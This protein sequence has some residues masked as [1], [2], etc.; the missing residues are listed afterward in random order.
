MGVKS[1]RAGIV[2]AVAAVPWAVAGCGSSGGG[3]NVVAPVIAETATSSGDGQTAQIGTLL[4]GALRVVVTLSGA[5]QQGTTVTWGTSATGA[6][7]NPTSSVTDA[8]GVATTAWTLGSAAGTQHA[9]ATLAGATGSPVTFSATA[10]AAPVPV[11]A[12][13]PTAS[14]NGQT[15][16]VATA[17]ANPLRVL[18]TLSG[19]VQQGVTVG[20]A[21]VG[22]GASVNPTTS[23][24]DA[25]GIAT[26]TWTLG[27]V[28]GAQSATATLAGATGSPVTFAATATPGAATQLLLSS[29]N[30]QSALVNRAFA[31]A[32][33]V[34]VGDQFANGVPGDSVSWLVTSGPA[35]ISPAK[36][37]SNAAG[38]AQASLT[39]G[40]TA[41]SVTVTAT[42][43]TL[44]GS[45]V[46]FNATVT[47]A[48]TTASVDI[49]NFF[50]KSGRNNSSNPAVDTIA[51]GGT[52]TWNFTGGTHGVQSTGT[53]SFT[54]QSTA[55]STGTFTFTFTS[56]GSYSYD[57]LV[58]GTLMTGI[59]VVQ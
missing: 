15:A 24:T 17:L 53:P 31:N 39:A 14:G 35:T 48:P 34:L 52:V 51:A 37:A 55:Q 43:G 44:T 58:H 6:S 49:G 59:I 11:I 29:G 12:M 30:N 2:V 42:S 1:V 4:A 10:T 36:S 38:L 5:P 22:T 19:A 57:C 40:A 32:L 8:G 23:M 9:T 13:T 20:W 21:A 50:F 25:T 54:G 3:T 46:T 27:H 26:T 18:V 47:T 45:P 28:S 7:V 33:A 41:G 56:A 16:T